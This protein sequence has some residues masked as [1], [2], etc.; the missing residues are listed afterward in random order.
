[1][2]D[3][4]RTSLW[5]TIA[6]TLGA[7]IA[8]G[9]YRTGDKLPTEAELAL[10]FGVNRHTIRRALAQLAE[11]GTV[12][13]RRGSGVFVTADPVDYAIGRRVSFS[14]NLAANGRIGSNQNTRAETLAATQT[15]AQALGLDAGALVHVIEGISL[16]DGQPIALSRSVF[17]A[18][19][20]PDFL[21]AMAQLAS[22]TA[23]LRACGVGD[24]TR[25]STRLTATSATAVQAA[26]LHIPQGAPILRSEALNIDA[27]SRPIEFGRTWFA[28]ERVTLTI[29]PD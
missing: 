1:M 6:S 17:P 22:V 20:L 27:Q 19:R 25:A 29:Q 23:A 14:Q 24:Y 18:D 8:Q 2:T 16:A 3:A 4:P 28:G 7:E 15:E 9:S 12:H 5:Q 11:A 10:R 21:Q 26:A 13:A